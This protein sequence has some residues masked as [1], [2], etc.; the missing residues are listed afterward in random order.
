M[1]IKLL[2]T[3]SNYERPLTT[4]G[5]NMYNNNCEWPLTTKGHNICIII[6]NLTV[7]ARTI[8]VPPSR[9]IT[10]D[11]ETTSV[12]DEF[13]ETCP[14]RYELNSPDRVL[15]AKGHHTWIGV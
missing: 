14:A 13:E 7:T 1:S 11:V 4:C 5:H 12:A 10:A 15:G 9:I 3:N 8:L 6:C 2:R